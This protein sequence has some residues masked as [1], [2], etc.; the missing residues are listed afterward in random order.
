MISLARAVQLPAQACNAISQ[1]FGCASR[2]S[3]LPIAILGAQDP[4]FR[5]PAQHR[6]AAGLS[7]FFCFLSPERQASR[8]GVPG[9]HGHPHSRLAAQPQ[10]QH[11]PAAG[12]GGGRAQAQARGGAA[13]AAADHRDG[14]GA[15]QASEG[16]ADG[17]AAAPAPRRLRAA[18]GRVRLGRLSV[19]TPEVGF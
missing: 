17:H 16:A 7:S 11:R 18:D 8:P 15:A 1:L 2:C 9:Q 14:A 5:V 12:A 3:L 10:Q 19:Q 13:A 6:A 4:F